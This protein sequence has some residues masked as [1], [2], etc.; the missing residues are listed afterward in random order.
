ML[1]SVH[2]PKCGG[3]T[4][5]RAVLEPVFG[6]RLLLDYADKPL[7]VDVSE[8]NAMAHTFSPAPR[9][10]EEYDCIHGHF[11]AVKYLSDGFP[12]QFAVWFR[13]P[14]QRMISRYHHSLRVARSTTVPPDLALEDFCALT[15]FRNTYAKYLW[16]FDLQD[17]DFIGIVEDYTRSLALFQRRFG[18]KVPLQIAASNANPNKGW[19]ERYPVPAAAARRIRKSNAEDVEIYRMAKDI[20]KRMCVRATLSIPD[21]C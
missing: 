15:R 3:S 20:Q 5:R 13:D 1:I 8:R 6:D 12:C 11:L 4:F 19:N 7:S 16:E 18:F 9:L 17:F 2:I 14:V 10:I 21:A